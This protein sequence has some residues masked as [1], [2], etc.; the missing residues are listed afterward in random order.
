MVMNNFF[1]SSEKGSYFLTFFKIYDI[2][3]IERIGKE[4]FNMQIN[5]FM[6]DEMAYVIYQL[7]EDEGDNPND[8][9]SLKAQEC[10]RR[11][12]IVAKYGF[13]DCISVDD[14]CDEVNAGGFTSYDGDGVV[15]DKFGNEL[16]GVWEGKTIPEEAAYVIW[17]N[18]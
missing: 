14:F 18:K 9:P 17:F 1:K 6:I 10:A 2:I 11:M 8:G 16:C 4:Y 7:Y 15:V 3:Y 13:G 12:A 5:D